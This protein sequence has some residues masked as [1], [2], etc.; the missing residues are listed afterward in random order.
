MDPSL[1]SVFH[2]NVST[3]NVKAVTATLKSHPEFLNAV[4]S[5]GRTPFSLI[6]EKQDV[7]MGRVLISH[8]AEM[9]TP[10]KLSILIVPIERQKEDVQSILGLTIQPLLA[11]RELRVHLLPDCG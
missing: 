4:D 2:R 3:G 8:G 9:L 7:K 10:D 5:E 6:C 11:F 1:L